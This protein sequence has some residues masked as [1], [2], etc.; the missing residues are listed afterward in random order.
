MTYRRE[1]TQWHLNQ[2]I[3]PV[4]ACLVLGRSAKLDELSDALDAAGRAYISAVL[5]GRYDHEELA[6]VQRLQAEVHA[7]DRRCRGWTDEA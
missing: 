4:Q 3:N 7:E 2:T 5:A 6:E 1:V